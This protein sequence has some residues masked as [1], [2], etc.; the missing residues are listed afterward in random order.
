MQTVLSNDRLTVAVNRKGAEVCSVKNK[1]GMEFIWQADPSV[2]NRHAPV[3]FPIVGKLK[4]NSFHHKGQ[5]YQLGQHGFAR[6]ME[7]ETG[8]S[9]AQSCTFTLRS[10]EKT[11]ET[12]PFDFTLNIQY[13]LQSNLLITTYEVHNPSHEELLF[14]IGA[15]PGFACPL[16]EFESYSDYYIDFGKDTLMQ[17]ALK[18]GLRNHHHK[19]T[20]LQG[21]RL[22]LSENLFDEDALVFENHQVSELSLCSSRSPRRISMSCEGWPYFGIWAKKASTRFLCLEPWHGIADSIHATGE[23]AE[24]EGIIRLGAGAAFSCSYSVCFE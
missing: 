8:P 4:N 23:F 6:D 7:F 13:E 22:Y 3:L 1:E 24:K 17:S 9:D 18:D 14:S 15:H 10:G 11:R 20:G 12:F 21:T 5:T 16:H 2:W 19:L